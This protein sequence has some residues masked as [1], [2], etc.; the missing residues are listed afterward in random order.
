M[1]KKIKL[2]FATT[3]DAHN[4]SKWSGTPFHMANAFEEEGI[5]I[6]YIGQL[7]R[8]LPAFFKIKQL[9][10]QLASG[11]RDSPRFNIVTARYYSEQVSK[12]LQSLTVDAIIAPQ[13]NPVAYLESKKPL[14]LWTDGLY[15]SLVG[16]YPGFSSHSTDTIRQG[17][18]ITR[19]C[20]SR[21]RLALFSSDW[22]ARTSIEIYGTDKDK[23]KVVPFGANLKTHNT[24]TDIRTMLAN[25]SRTVVKLLFLGKH[26]DR[27]GGDIVFRVV[28]AL[29]A[30][31]QPVELHFVG[32]MPPAGTDIPA[33]IH[34]HGFISKRTP[35]GVAQMTKLLRE[36][37][38]LFVPSRAEAYGIVFCEANAY[39][40]PCLTSFV[41]GISTIVKD[42]INGM[43]FALDADPQIYCRYIISLMQNYAQYEELA[44]SSFHEFDT[45]LNWKIAVKTVTKLIREL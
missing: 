34:C 8:R 12:Q 21:C 43:T 15:S 42:N 39:G 41:G 37:H 31:G 2:A 23:V 10:K 40:L 13:I 20:L 45:R 18:I 3:F 7:K 27:K 35:E 19:E 22:A 25:R 11:E 24:L 17:N 38:F 6:E 36:S 1:M 44:L 14:I 30:A 32:C 16:F 4:I 28:K 9:W 33:F 26:W 29:H 5:P